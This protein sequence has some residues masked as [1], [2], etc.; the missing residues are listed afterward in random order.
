MDEVVPDEPEIKVETALDGLQRGSQ[1]LDAIKQLRKANRA[2]DDQPVR[3][4]QQTDTPLDVTLRV[5]RE[6]KLP[7]SRTGRDLLIFPQ[8]HRHQFLLQAEHRL[9]DPFLAAG[10]ELWACG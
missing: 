9:G 4:G 1:G 8:G 3:R 5:C 7:H 6:G 10:G 2:H